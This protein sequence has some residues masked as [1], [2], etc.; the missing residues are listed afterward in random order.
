MLQNYSTL[1]LG[2]WAERERIAISLYEP[3]FKLKWSLHVCLGKLIPPE[4]GFYPIQTR[5]CRDWQQIPSWG[6]RHRRLR[7]CYLFHGGI[8]SQERSGHWMLFLAQC[9]MNPLFQEK[10]GKQKSVNCSIEKK[11]GHQ[12]SNGCQRSLAWRKLAS[13]RHDSENL[14]FF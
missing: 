8:F 2:F 9:G 11:W 13:R 14:I 5:H 4:I 12:Q 10:V 3:V 7:T 6:F 1:A